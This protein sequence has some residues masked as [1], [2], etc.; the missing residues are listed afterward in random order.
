[1]TGPLDLSPLSPVPAH[2]GYP[3]PVAPPY[4]I[5]LDGTLYGRSV[6]QA[7]LMLASEFP[8]PRQVIVD[9]TGAAGQVGGS[10]SLPAWIDPDDPAWRPALQRV[11]AH[12]Q[13]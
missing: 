5:Q 3:D 11:L 7:L 9:V 12:H 2:G 6:T 1:M 4:R 13:R 10:I 8:G